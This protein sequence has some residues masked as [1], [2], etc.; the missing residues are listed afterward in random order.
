MLN[1]VMPIAGAG[2]RFRGAGNPKPLIPIH[3]RPM[4]VWAFL[5]LAV[6]VQACRPI[7]VMLREHAE[8]FN[9]EAIL[10]ANLRHAVFVLLDRPTGGSLET[11]LAAE[12]IIPRGEQNLVVLDC[13]LVFASAAFCAAVAG[14]SA[15]PDCNAGVLL[16]FPSTDPRYSYAQAQSGRVIRTAEKDVISTDAL[17]GAYAFAAART[18]FDM[19]KEIVTNNQRVADGEFYTS[20]VYN[21]LIARGAIVKLTR[22]EA[23]WSLGTPEELAATSA[24][25]DF[26]PFLE[27]LLS[28]AARRD[29]LA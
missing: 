4:A 3:G 29:I 11:S 27:K 23:Y 16:S 7:F 2:S 6:G 17:A 12:G 8:K 5:S 24:S 15:T 1:V 18:F 26:E 14:L 22:A 9:A 28:E 19:A 20:A 10:A 25:P 13:D 21:K